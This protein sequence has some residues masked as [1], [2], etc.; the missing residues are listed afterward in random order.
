M[1]KAESQLSNGGKNFCHALQYT[2]RRTAEK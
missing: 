1:N 2:N